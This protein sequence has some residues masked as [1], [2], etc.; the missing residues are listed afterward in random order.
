[1]ALCQPHLYRNLLLAE[2]AELAGV[3]RLMAFP[4]GVTNNYAYY[5]VSTGQF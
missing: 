1:M 4:G 2:R 5:V 3:R